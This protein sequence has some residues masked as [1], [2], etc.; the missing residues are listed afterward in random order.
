MEDGSPKSV[1]GSPKHQWLSAK[2]VSK[3]VF[4]EDRSK[5]E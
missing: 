4:L 2:A 1:G 3:A 5:N